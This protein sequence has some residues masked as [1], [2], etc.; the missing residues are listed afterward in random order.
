MK[1]SSW[2][3]HN[4]ANISGKGVSVT[5]NLQSKFWNLKFLLWDF[6]KLHAYNLILTF[7]VYLWQTESSIPKMLAMLHGGHDEDCNST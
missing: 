5:I 6:P 2:A 1:S 3:L 7:I 4:G